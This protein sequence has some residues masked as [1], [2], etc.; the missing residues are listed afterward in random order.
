[1]TGPR[2]GPERR[3]GRRTDRP[4]R[5]LEHVGRPWTAG[6]GLDVFAVEDRTAQL[7]WSNLLAGPV[8]VT[9]TGPGGDR[10]ARTVPHDGGPGAVELAALRPGSRHTVEVRAAHDIRARRSLQTQPAAPGEE[11]FR[12]ATMNDLHLGREEHPIHGDG[13]RPLAEG[14]AGAPSPADMAA[15]ATS[16]AL[17][18]GA[19]AIVVKG[20][21]CDQSYDHFWDQ[22]ADLFGNLAVP[23][24]MLPG[25]HDT[26]SRRQVEPEVA[27]AARGLHMS[28]GVEAVDVAGLK[29][30]MVESGLPGNGW[31]SMARHGNDVADL[32]A[33]ARAAGV[34]TFIATH[35]QAQR[36]RIPLYWPHG[37]PGP[38]AAEFARSVR[39]AGTDVLASSGHTHR[40]RRRVVAGLTWSEIAATNHFPAVWAGYRVFDGGLMQVV[41][42]T[43]TPR[44]L[45]WSDQTR[46]AFNG[47]WALWSTGTP[48]DRNFTLPWG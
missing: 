15:D 34:G 17:A 45:T 6:V 27:A 12:F 1:M 21:V 29:I 47:A 32:V 43:A 4:Q 38:D 36:Y 46:Q 48:S 13:K 2:R 23:V 9:V 20:D 14:G 28:R 24:W 37:T 44:A 35:H 11:L 3:L 10:S 31:G 16:D 33:D 26:G 30:V 40:C 8:T 25:N 7:I 39:A 19:Q 22:A 42:R 18:W 41:R 5:T